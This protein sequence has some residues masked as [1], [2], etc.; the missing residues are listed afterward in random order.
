MIPAGEEI[1]G[2][3]IAPYLC[4]DF[5]ARFK[6]Q[7]FLHPKNRWICFYVIATIVTLAVTGVKITV[8]VQQLR[9]RRNILSSPD[10]QKS[11]RSEKLKVHQKRLISTS[12]SIKLIYASVLVACAEQVPMGIL[13][14]ILHM[15]AW[16]CLLQCV[17]VHV[18]MLCVHTCW[19]LYA[20]EH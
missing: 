9:E 19:A 11:D 1:N 18:Y 16:I 8:F 17:K 7:L 6:D 15:H 5:N 3:L 10:D 4:F 2:D 12:R 20:S 14:G 13:Q